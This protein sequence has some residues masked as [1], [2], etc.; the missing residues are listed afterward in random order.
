MTKTLE[1]AAGFIW[2]NARLLDRHR[3]GFHFEDG[4]A[5]AVVDAL[6]AYQNPDGGFGN[7]LEADIRAP[8]SQPVPAE[9]ALRLLDEVDQMPAEVVE[10]LCDWLSSVS[11]EEGG[12]PFVLPTVR[13]YPHAPWWDPDGA[14]PGAN[15]NPTA[16]IAGILAGRGVDHPWV[17]P[18]VEFAW[19]GI[20]A[21]A[22]GEMHALVCVLAFLDRAPDRERAAKVLEGARDLVL[23]S[24]SLDPHTTEYVKHPLDF[25]P[26][27]DRLSRSLFTDDQIEAD[28]D[29]LVA[30]QQPDGGW[31]VPWPAPSEAAL[32]EWRGA[33]TV[34][35]LVTLRAYGRL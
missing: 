33:N 14:S 1:A 4:P 30:R 22:E 11:T 27:P 21:L 31:P 35:A 2:S 20:E 24:V 17:A 12:V 32:L 16:G 6:R 34:D 8:S 3:Y 23:A 15:V 5:D 25:A 29:G 19:C 9:W 26:S 7:A 13:G 28:L 10:P 18:A